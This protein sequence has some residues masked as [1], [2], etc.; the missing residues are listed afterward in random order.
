MTPQPR[1]LKDLRGYSIVAYSNQYFGIPKEIGDIRLDRIDHKTIPQIIAR[2]SLSELEDAINETW[3]R[4][5]DAN[6]P[7]LVDSVHGYNIVAYKGAFFGVPQTLGDVKLDLIDP[8]SVPSIVRRNTLGELKDEIIAR[9]AKTVPTGIPQLICDIGSYNIVLFDGTYY[10][11]PKA[12]GDYRLEL[13]GA[14]KRSGLIREQTLAGA[15]AE[16]KRR[17]DTAAKGRWFVHLF[18]AR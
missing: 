6:Q 16:V 17:E 14:A 10:G 2:M 3:L 8:D 12:W 7:R 18:G 15:R 13:G 11:I 9:W 4:S 5:L 1:L